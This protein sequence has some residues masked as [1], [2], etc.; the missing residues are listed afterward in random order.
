MT[1]FFTLY[2]LSLYQDGVTPLHAASCNGHV[3]T[4][5]LL[6]DNAAV[7]DF[8]SKVKLL[9]PLHYASSQGHKEIVRLL[10]DKGANIEAQERVSGINANKMIN[11]NGKLLNCTE[12]IC[13]SFLCMF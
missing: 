9:T 11:F 10:L 1:Y 6:L 13:S 5:R 2:E 3:E 7:V 4:V 8:P 12:R